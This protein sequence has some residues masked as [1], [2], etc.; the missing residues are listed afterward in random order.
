ALQ[1]SRVDLNES[2]KESARGTTVGLRQNRL[3]AF[4]IVSEVSLA[5]VLM[6]GAALLTKSFVR[7]LD[8]NPGFDPSSTLTMEVTLPTAPPSKYADEQQQNLFFQQVLDRL[9]HTPGVTAAGAVLSLTLTGAEESTYLFIEGHP[10]PPPEQR[11]TTDYTVV[12]AEYFRALGIPLLK[13]RAFNDHDNKDTAGV[14]IIN[15]ALARRD[16]PNEEPLGKK[17]RVG[18]EQT[19]REI[20]GVV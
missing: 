14:I 16:W 2:L 15:E 8:V 19:P 1:A 9:N 17:A 6:I 7:L 13:G 12:T 10:T 11:L 20:I 4:L 5:V 3:R 18:F